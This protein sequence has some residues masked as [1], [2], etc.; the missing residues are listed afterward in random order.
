MVGTKV[1]MLENLREGSTRQPILIEQTEDLLKI[2][3]LID[4]EGV[5]RPGWSVK[6]LISPET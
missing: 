6:L 1:P 5:T 4:R 2:Q 3:M